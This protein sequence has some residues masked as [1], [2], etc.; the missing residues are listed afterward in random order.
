MHKRLAMVV[1]AL[2]MMAGCGDSPTEPTGPG[3]V[4]QV[5]ITG[6]PQV[7]PV[8]QSTQ[9]RALERLNNGTSRDCTATATWRSADPVYVSVSAQGVATALRTGTPVISAVCNGVEGSVRLSLLAPIS[10]VYISTDGR[11]EPMLAGWAMQLT[12]NVERTDISFGLC[13]GP[14]TWQSSNEAVATVNGGGLLTARSRG[15]ATVTASCDGKSATRVFRVIEGLVLIVDVR[16]ADVPMPL[17]DSVV[18][19]LDGPRAGRYVAGPGFTQIEDVTLPLRLRVSSPGYDAVETVVT[20]Q[21]GTASPNSN[22]VQV[23]QALRITPQPGAED[24]IGDA[25]NLV[26]VRHTFRVRRAGMFRAQVW[27]YHDYNDHLAT[28]L[29]CGS[30]VLASAGQMEQA[31]GEGFEIAVEPCDVDVVVRASG[32]Y[33]LTRFRLRVSYPG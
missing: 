8:G 21:S 1:V 23:G 28:E 22:V 3:T 26:P 33:Q 12:L 2:A 9:L 32:R 16:D 29:L 11:F 6:V 7:L 14:A 30:R 5:E 31:R 25:V 24:I 17:R 13:T 20:E 4:V 19:V 18:E 10:K 27:W 15:E